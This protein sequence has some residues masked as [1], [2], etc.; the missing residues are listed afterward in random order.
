MS[1]SVFFFA[2][3]RGDAEFA[4]QEKLTSKKKGSTRRCGR[5]ALGLFP[6]A[7]FFSC[8]FSPPRPVATGLFLASA[9]SRNKRKTRENVYPCDWADTIGRPR[10]K[11]KRANRQQTAKCLIGGDRH[12]SQQKEGCGS[13]D[14]RRLLRPKQKHISPT[15]RL[16]VFFPLFFLKRKDIGFLFF[17]WR[18]GLFCRRDPL[19][20]CCMFGRTQSVRHPGNIH[21]LESHRARLACVA[22]P[23]CARLCRLVSCA[24]PMVAPC[25]AGGRRLATR[26]AC[27]L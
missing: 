20:H 25:A 22:P 24:S 27:P 26:G 10:R 9:A 18:D 6:V 1:W 4:Y 21:A 16:L 15:G 5:G 11:E 13:L 17:F 3:C 7:R 8:L 2:G 12:A 23:L 19:G 14:A